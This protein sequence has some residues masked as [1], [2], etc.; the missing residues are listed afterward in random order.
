LL[1][2]WL[3]IMH[4]ITNMIIPKGYKIIAGGRCEAAHPRCYYVV[5]IDPERVADS[6]TPSGSFDHCNSVVSLRSTTG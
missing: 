5:N 6:S 2:G 1:F 3:V 4:R